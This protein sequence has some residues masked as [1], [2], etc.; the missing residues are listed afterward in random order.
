MPRP[1]VTDVAPPAGSRVVGFYPSTD[2][3]DAY[4]IELPD[5]ACGDPEALARF[6]F[7]RSPAW[8]SVLMG[9]RDTLVA[10]LGLKTA[11][12]L[13]ELGADDGERV[14]IFRI[15]ERRPAE[16]LLGEDDKHL[17]FR[18]SVLCQPP[19]AAGDKR[20]LIVSTVV[21]CHNALGR[22]YLAV[23]APFHRRILRAS[24]ANA[25][26]IGWPPQPAR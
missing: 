2:L 14:G 10:G 6:V 17:D 9:I 25:A 16:L 13:R 21:H 24:L 4:S 19:A 20:R 18:L 1:L 12:G 8:M 7:A 11:H 3:C 5:D 26:R 15:Y 23:V 22:G